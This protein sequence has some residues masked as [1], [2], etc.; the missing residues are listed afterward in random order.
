MPYIAPSHNLELATE[1]SNLAI[2]ATVAANALT[3]TAL[4]KNYNT[5]TTGN[6]ATIAFRSADVEDANYSS[7]YIT[8]NISLVI[9]S[10]STL[11]STN[12]AGQYLYVYVINNAGTVELACSST[13]YDDDKLITTLAEGG[14]GGADSPQQ[15]YSTTARTNVPCRLVA[16]FLSTQTTAGTW[17]VVPSL[18]SMGDF[19][20]AP[21]TWATSTSRMEWARITFSSGTPVIFATSSS[22]ITSI[23]DTGT[24]DVTLNF[25]PFVAAP[26]VSLTAENTTSDRTSITVGGLS[27]TTV[28]VVISRSDTAT[29]ID[30]NFF[31]IAI[32]RSA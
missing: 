9:S 29:L 21:Q 2:Q 13:L 4:D 24:G 27:T 30:S 15:V 6:P 10:G 28:R 3:F 26:F 1:V 16:R 25:K 32:G 5:L 23:T 17:A 7:A 12:N 14:A 19:I 22:W 20:S 11:G 8:S 18:A 31:I